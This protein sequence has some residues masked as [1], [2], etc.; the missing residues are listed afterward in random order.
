MEGIIW[1]IIWAIRSFIVKRPTLESFDVWEPI[2]TCVNH[3]NVHQNRQQ[4]ICL[5]P[6]HIFLKQQS[7]PGKTL[8]ES[9]DDSQK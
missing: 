6:H 5:H 2:S 7:T 8:I 3:Q 1:A 4:S 9:D